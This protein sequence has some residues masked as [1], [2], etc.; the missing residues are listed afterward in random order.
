M[1]KS[2]KQL[3]VLGR[4]CALSGVL[5][6]GHPL[7]DQI[8]RT[9][10]RPDKAGCYAV[11]VGY[12][13]DAFAALTSAHLPSIDNNNREPNLDDPLPAGYHSPLLRALHGPARAR[14]A[15][16]GRASGLQHLNPSQFQALDGMTRNLELVRGPPGT[17]KST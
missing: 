5:G 6:F 9:Y 13:G 16:A 14:V 8:D 7:I 1:S 11:V 10:A 4:D 15:A 17:G 12:V 2:D 3:A